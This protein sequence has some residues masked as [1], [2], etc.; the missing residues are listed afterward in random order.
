MAVL[1]AAFIDYKNMIFFQFYTHVERILRMRALKALSWR[2]H[3]H[4]LINASF[5]DEEKRNSE[6]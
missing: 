4:H 6:K 5:T 2:Q 1:F 3:R